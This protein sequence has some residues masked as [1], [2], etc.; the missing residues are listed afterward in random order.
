MLDGGLSHFGAM[1]PLRKAGLA[2][3]LAA[4]V[5]SATYLLLRPSDATLRP[6]EAVDVV[7]GDT[8]VVAGQV[9]DLEGIDAP[10]L[11]Q[12]C[13]GEH[14]WRSCG[15][16]AAKALEQLVGTDTAKFVC[17]RQQS[18]ENALVARCESD[19][20]DLS[21]AMLES[22][23]AMALPASPASYR[24]AA[25]RARERHLGVWAGGMAAPWDWRLGR[26]LPGE[27]EARAG[28]D[29][30]KAMAMG[31]NLRFYYVP[32]DSE[33]Q[34][35]KVD[36]GRGDRRFCSDEDARSHGWTRPSQ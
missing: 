6:E 12:L 7:D 32:T 36:V 4:A 15:I 29:V 27:K 10:E 22:G 5:A 35:L 20:R 8:L 31:R 21:Q 2:A 18:R 17:T 34:D 33:Y 24:D 9:V 26:L 28:C 30:V 23:M 1:S 16:E 13:R 25:R 3:I 11:G 19:G 14:D